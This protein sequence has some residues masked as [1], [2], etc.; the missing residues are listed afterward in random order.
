MLLVKRAF[1]L[2]LAG[3]LEAT[4]FLLKGTCQGRPTVRM[5]LSSGLQKA[6]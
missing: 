2:R 4:T 1:T 3:S 6:S 5:G